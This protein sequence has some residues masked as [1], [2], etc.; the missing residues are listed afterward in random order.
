[1]LE[2]S[3][4]R[5]SAQSSTTIPLETKVPAETRQQ[6]STA[7]DLH[8]IPLSI[9]ADCF[10]ACLEV[11]SEEELGRAA[12]YRVAAAR[13]EFIVSHAALRCLLAGYLGCRPSEIAYAFGQHGKPELTGFVPPCDWQFNL[14]H[15]RGLAAIAVTRG[16]RIGVDIECQREFRGRTESLA[17]TILAGTEF[18]EYQQLSETEQISSLLRSWTL[19]EAL[20]KALGVGLAVSPQQVEFLHSTSKPPQLISGGSAAAAES[21]QLFQPTVSADHCVAIATENLSGSL[22][23]S[24][25]GSRNWN[26]AV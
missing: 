9:P 5:S 10:E 8:L 25:H 14:S 19:K 2:P 16:K 7:I 24:Q 11:L 17:K 4:T 15:S 13:T 3:G 1:M 21:W 12:R 26:R 6:W 18:E 20:L 22:R 23:V